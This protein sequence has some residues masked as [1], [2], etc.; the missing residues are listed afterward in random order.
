MKLEK[1]NCNLSDYDKLHCKQK[2]R[3]EMAY[4]GADYSGFQSQRDKK[5]IQDYIEKAL[6]VFLKEPTRIKGSSRTD[7]GVH[8]Y[9]QIATFETT[10]AF[11]SFRLLE[12]LNALLPKTIGIKSVAKVDPTFDPISHA[13]AKI[14]RYCLWRGKC[15]NPFLEPYVWNVSHNLCVDTLQESLTKLIGEHDFTSFCN[16][17]SGARTKVRNILDAKVVDHGDRIDIWF[18][19][20]GFLKQM[21]RII[22]GTLV[23]LSEQ[24]ISD[25]NIE[26][27]LLTKSR[28]KAGQ[29]AP[30]QG[31][32]LV[33]VYYD[34]VPTIDAVLARMKSQSFFLF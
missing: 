26:T 18:L 3:L 11:D 4:L 17:D 19:G 15:F 30:P 25:T 9:G 2:Y 14:Y 33:E 29:T 23:D 32:S 20:E 1:K 21:V 27:I 28:T 24:R 31:L 5:A 16:T 10:T 22:V 13:K 7:S 34:C 6:E 8:A 12:S